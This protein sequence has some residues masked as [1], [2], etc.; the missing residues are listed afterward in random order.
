MNME[1]KGGGVCG[2][3]GICGGCSYQ[4]MSYEEQLKLKES[5]VLR[6]LKE[7]HIEYGNFAGIKGSPCVTAYR[8]KMEYT[9]GDM[10]KGGEM[11]LGLHRKKS[12]MTV[13]NADNCMLCDNDFNIITSA[14]LNFC[15]LKG[16]SHYNRK[17]HRGLL[18]NLLLR[19]GENTGELLVCIV[20]TSESGFDA[21]AFADMVLGLEL[22]NCVVGIMHTKNDNIADKVT[23]ESTDVLYGRDYYNERIMGL[24]F[25]VNIFAF[26]QTNVAAAERMYGE[27][28]GLIDDVSGKTVFD[29]Y[30]GT[31]TITQALARSAKE[32]IGVELS[33]D[34]VNSAC[35]NAALN[36]LNNCR[37]I[38]GD[39][40]KVM[41][42]IAEKPD[43]IVVD[44]PR[45]GLHF[46]VLP[47]LLSYGVGQILY[48][49]CNPVT[50]AENLQFMQENGYRTEAVKVYDNFPFTRSIESV[51][52]LGR[53]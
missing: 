39:V 51:C 15:K 31:G 27:A 52:L 2:L 43:V 41:D 46:K 35:M 53:D 47:K 13:L 49:S 32:A 12:F 16:Y 37:F 6:L 14:V 25:R 5:E 30:C 33:A 36:N 48:I 1:I 34:A 4:G 19:K 11:T 44:P 17:T 18:R 20:T 45:A 23:N 3:G 10:T 22:K 38:E 26:F 50:L 7:K 28:I 9:F 42:E 40:L 21:E 8:N 24:D 29:L